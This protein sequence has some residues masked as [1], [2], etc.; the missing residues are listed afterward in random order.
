[1]ND[2]E[3]IVN[4]KKEELFNKFRPLVMREYKKISQYYFESFE[5]FLGWAWEIFI[6][7]FNA[8][9]LEKIKKP[10]EYGF[11]IQF[12][13]YLHTYLN[14][15]VI[16]KE[17]QSTLSLNYHITEGDHGN[18]VEAEEALVDNRYD[19]LEIPT[20]LEKP[21]EILSTCTTAME[22]RRKLIDRGYKRREIY[23]IINS[24]KRIIS[25]NKYIEGDKA[26]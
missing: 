3:L 23:D 15:D 1:M 19:H 8:V 25:D 20:E 9:K 22:F 26:K 13:M 18:Y 5:D 17:K 24:F 6:K 7:A 10:E 4:D 11:Y 2:Y 16:K 12:Y 14:Q 21:Y